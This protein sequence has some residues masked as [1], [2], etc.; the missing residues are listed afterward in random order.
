MSA[1]DDL[2]PGAQRARNPRARDEYVPYDLPHPHRYPYE[3]D[4][5][6][7]V[8]RS[9]LDAAVAG[10]SY[11]C[12][13]LGDVGGIVDPA[14]QRA[15]ARAMCALAP[16]A[17]RYDAE[18]RPLGDTL[19]AY[20]AGDVV[21]N[22]GEP[23]H[24]AEQ[25]YAPYRDYDRPILAIPGNHDGGLDPAA[26]DYPSLAGFVANFCAPGRAI[27]G[28][29]T[30]GRAP[31]G[32]PNVYWTLEAPWLRIVG[33]YTNVPEGGVVDDEQRHW[34]HA[35]L[36][37]PRGDKHLVVALHQPVF[38]CDTVHG[39]SPDMFDLVHESARRAGC[40][41]VMSGHAHNYQR[42]AYDGVTYVVNGAGGYHGLHDLVPP[43][44]PGALYPLVAHTRDHSFMHLTVTPRA[45]TARIVAVPLPV[46]VTG[47]PLVVDEFA[48]AVTEGVRV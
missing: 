35:Q 32:Q 25:F 18:R 45:L 3:L 27:P 30:Y 9:R 19:F 10:G 46:D 37:G 23:A 6:D 47:R 15:V 2:R 17:R 38:S 21:Y 31:A 36:A 11:S 1:T 44:G 22:N 7:V 20:I 4:L 34:F 41:L 13:L 39:G 12:Y 5:A 42:F 43:A 29:T 24:Y 14:P 33:L 16:G 40:R 48:V 8:G 26:G 28:T